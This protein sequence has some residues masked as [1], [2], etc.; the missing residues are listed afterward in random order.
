[1]TPLEN[2]TV[3]L[4]ELTK[5]AER[6][7]P[8][9]WYVAHD[10]AE[11]CGPHARSGLAL[12]D[13]GTS[14]WTCARLCEWPTARAIAAFGTHGKA[15]IESLRIA[16]EAMAEVERTYCVERCGEAIAAISAKL[17]EVSR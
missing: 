12:V 11:E 17:G 6:A 3:R 7:T 15:L 13:N 9:P 14:A 8:G 16:V 1:M 4:A 5:L 2:I 10:S